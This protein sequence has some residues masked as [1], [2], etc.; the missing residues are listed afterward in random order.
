[1]PIYSLRGLLNLPIDKMKNGTYRVRSYVS[2]KRLKTVYKTRAAAVK[3]AS[4]SKRRS[5]RKRST[6]SKRAK[7]GGYY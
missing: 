5:K 7:K 1:L 2:G 3:A 6:G 4:T